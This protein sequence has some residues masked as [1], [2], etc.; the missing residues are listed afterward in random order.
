MRENRIKKEMNKWYTD[1]NDEKK[2]RKYYTK[3]QEYRDK[4]LKY[5]LNI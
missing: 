1:E 3:E 4:V 2:I 5:I